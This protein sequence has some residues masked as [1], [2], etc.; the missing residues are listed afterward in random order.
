MNTASQFLGDVAMSESD[1]TTFT[2]TDKPVKR[3]P[4]LPLF[5][6]VTKH[7]AKKI[8]PCSVAAEL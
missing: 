6:H 1:S 7:W 8:N 4:D 3:Y 5:P 2:P